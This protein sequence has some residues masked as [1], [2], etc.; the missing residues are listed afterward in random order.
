VTDADGDGDTTTIDFSTFLAA[1]QLGET[2]PQV[3]PSGLA[4]AGVSI[5]CVP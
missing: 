5:P 2:V 3:G 1:F 4:C